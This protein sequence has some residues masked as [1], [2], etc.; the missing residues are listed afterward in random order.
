MINK[1]SL[2]VSLWIY[3]FNLFDAF[4]SFV[5]IIWYLSHHLLMGI[6][7]PWLLSPFDM[8]LVFLDGFLASWYD[9][10]FQLHIVHILPPRGI[11]HFSENSQ[12]FWH[13]FAISFVTVSRVFHWTRIETLTHAHTHLHSVRIKDLMG[14]YW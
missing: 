11:S 8:I 4:V 5:V 9:K 10:I 3:A 13:S 6:S 14:S 1:N 7:S 2:L 12:F